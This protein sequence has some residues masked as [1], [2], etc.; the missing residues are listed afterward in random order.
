MRQKVQRERDERGLIAF[1]DAAGVSKGQIVNVCKGRRACTGK[2]A[3]Y[4]GYTVTRSSTWTY[5]PTGD[6]R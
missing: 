1:A 2:L 3:S 6:V 4:F 5:E